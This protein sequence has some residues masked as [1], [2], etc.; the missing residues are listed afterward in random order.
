MYI[1]YNRDPPHFSVKFR[2]TGTIISLG[3]GQGMAGIIGQPDLQT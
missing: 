3:D 1:Q 2:T